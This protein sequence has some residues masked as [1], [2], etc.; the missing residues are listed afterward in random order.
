MGP[1]TFVRW[2]RTTTG[3]SSDVV[4]VAA[5]GAGSTTCARA[6]SSSVRHCQSFSKRSG[7][8][9]GGVSPGIGFG[10]GFGDD[11]ALGRGL[12]AAGRPGCRRREGRPALGAR[13]VVPVHGH[14][15][16][17]LDRARAEGRARRVLHAQERVRRRRPERVDGEGH[18]EDRPVD[19][20]RRQEAGEP[21][22]H[23]RPEDV[24]HAVEERVDRQR[25]DH[26]RRRERGR[27]DGDAGQEAQRR[28]GSRRRRV[29]A[30]EVVVERLAERQEPR[31][32]GHGF[33][34]RSAVGPGGGRRGRGGGG[35]VAV[36]VRGGAVR[37]ATG[38]GRVRLADRDAVAGR[39]AVGLRA[40]LVLVLV[41]AR[42]VDARVEPDDLADVAGD[43]RSP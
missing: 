16:E 24:Q 43:L 21:S 9:I 25:I 10:D 5:S 12:G 29:L 22:V 4:A 20:M 36:A 33:V 11:L 26:T 40:V 3:G 19:L 30:D 28:L 35:T 41:E 18:V 27:V 2:S 34:L 37:R 6:P 31:G 8:M 32:V 38:R 39:V 1:L 15:D 42:V 13:R 23:D 7:A 17:L 14:G